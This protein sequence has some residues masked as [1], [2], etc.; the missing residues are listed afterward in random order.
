MHITYNN[1]H[2]YTL[3]K[4]NVADGSM[5]QVLINVRA[6]FKHCSL[7]KLEALRFG[8][9]DHAFHDLLKQPGIEECLILQ[10]CNRVEIFAVGS[11]LNISEKIVGYWKSSAAKECF[12][13]EDAIEVSSNYEAV[14]HLLS[15]SAGLESMVVGEDQIL[16]Q[17]RNAYLDAQKAHA[18]GATLR[19]LFDNTLQVGCRVRRETNVNKGAVSVGSIAVQDAAKILGGLDKKKVMLLGVGE[20]GVQVGKA[21]R[22]NGVSNFFIVSRL[23]ERAQAL[24]SVVGGEPIA[25][26]DALKR[27]GEVD[28]IIVCTSAPHKFLT[29][30]KLQESSRKNRRWKLLIFDLSNPRNVSDDVNQIEGVK[31]RTL[32]SLRKIAKYN[33]ESRLKEASAAKVLVESEAEALWRKLCRQWYAEPL[34]SRIFADAEEL[35]K[36]ELDRALRAM[37]MHSPKEREILGNMTRSLME[38]ILLAPVARLRQAAEEGNMTTCH[39]GQILFEKPKPDRQA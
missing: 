39:Y 18:V 17:I 34:I 30:E 2:T 24:A 8:N 36:R 4:A 20:V 12:P 10:T 21:L 22:K 3:N 9:V 33:L 5:P 37:G 16:G 14:L 35:R 25:F 27:L 11:E 7:P 1:S 29:K 31:L 26:D 23:L 19:A 32:D 38:G 13:W 15:L 28:V 6:V